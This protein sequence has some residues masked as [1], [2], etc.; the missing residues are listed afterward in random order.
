MPQRRRDAT[1]SC[2]TGPKSDRGTPASRV[3][4]RHTVRI[5]TRGRQFESAQHPATAPRSAG[6]GT[7]T[8]S[9][10]TATERV[11]VRRT[12]R[13]ESRGPRF[14]RQPVGL[15]VAAVASLRIWPLRLV[16]L[17]QSTAAPASRGPLPYCGLAAWF[18]QHWLGGVSVCGRLGFGLRALWRLPSPFPFLPFPP[19]NA[20]RPRGHFC[21]RGRFDCFVKRIVFLADFA[22]L[23]ATYS[24]V[25]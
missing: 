4:W 17:S 12:K 22:G 16:R 13:Q 11:A 8:R 15:W 6:S 21:L 10:G 18:G 9:A 19:V 7:N 1:R 14:D 24:P 23:A 20:K 3:A 5:E 25:S 2:S